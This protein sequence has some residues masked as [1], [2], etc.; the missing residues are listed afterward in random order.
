MIRICI[1]ENS[2]YFYDL[3]IPLALRRDSPGAVSM[4]FDE[5]MMEHSEVILV[6]MSIILIMGIM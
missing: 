4:W 3:H 2:E 6:I 1:A 5:Q